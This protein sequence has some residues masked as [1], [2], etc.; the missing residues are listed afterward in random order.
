M[1]RQPRWRRPAAVFIAFMT[2]AG[3]LALWPQVARAAEFMAHKAFY[4]MKP[5]TFESGS[6]F[7]GVTGSMELS[8]EQNCSGWSMSQSLQMNLQL[9][10]GNELQQFHRYTGRESRNGTQYD[11]F[12]TSRI[13][14]AREDFRGRAILERS[15]GPGYA[16]F[17][18]PE[19]VKLPLPEGTLF[20]L[21]HTAYLIDRATAGERFASAIVFDGAD[22]G[23]P[24]EVTAFI[25]RKQHAGEV[26][27]IEKMKS[28]G[29]MVDRSGWKTRM[30]FYKLDSQG[31]VPEYEVEALQLDNGVT[32]WMLLDY[33]DF[34]VVLTMQNLEEIPAPKC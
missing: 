32:P 12:S 19:D 10:N 8:M 7:A 23:G 24:Q 11:F 18:V 33:H 28:L 26:I 3:G 6:D 30:A 16:S 13:V 20:P 1:Y 14:D 27:G 9:A 2:L 21:G 15:G 29:K 22:D 5:G 4:I 34:S 31:A 17:R 25:G